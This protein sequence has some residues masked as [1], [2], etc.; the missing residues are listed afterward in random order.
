MGTLGLVIDG[1]IVGEQSDLNTPTILTSNGPYSVRQEQTISVT[2]RSSSPGGVSGAKI[3]IGFPGTGHNHPERSRCHHHP[4]AHRWYHR[5]PR[6]Q[7]LNRGHVRKVTS[8]KED[9]PSP[10]CCLPF[11]GRRLLHLIYEA[12][13]VNCPSARRAS[14]KLC[15][16]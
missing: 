4:G 6:L 5:P 8:P 10:Q 14:P 7:S 11:S 3:R 1:Q 15:Y 13:H 9:I 16:L 12:F 2:Y